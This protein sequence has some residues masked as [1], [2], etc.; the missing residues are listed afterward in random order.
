MPEDSWDSREDDQQF[1]EWA[2]EVKKRDRFA[3]QICSISGGYMEAHHLNGWNWSKDERYDVSNG[4]CLCKRCH[5]SFHD[6]YG[7]G[8]NTRYQFEQYNQISLIFK[9]VIKKEITSYGL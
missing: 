8:Y 7:F 3:C 5:K 4:I 6:Q 1:K 9:L 2:L